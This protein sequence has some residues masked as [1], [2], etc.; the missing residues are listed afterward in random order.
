VRNVYTFNFD[1][2]QIDVLVKQLPSTMEQV[3]RDLAGFTDFLEQLA[4]EG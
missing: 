1:A 2:G 3:Y 4:D